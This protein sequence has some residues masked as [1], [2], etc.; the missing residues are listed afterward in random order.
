[1]TV[2]YPFNDHRPEF[3]N[4]AGEAVVNNAEEC[5]EQDPESNSNCQVVFSTDFFAEDK[6]GDTVSYQ[7]IPPSVLF[8]IRDAKNLSSLYYRGVGISQDTDIPLLIQVDNDNNGN[9]LINNK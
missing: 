6:D 3:N 2:T 9:N 4:I 7:I 1:M 5:D 8:G